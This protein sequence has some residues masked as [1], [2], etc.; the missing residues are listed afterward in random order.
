MATRYVRKYLNFDAKDVW[1]AACAAQRINNGSYI[2]LVGPDESGE[3]N[4]NIMNRMLADTTQITDA[5]RECGDTVR[6]YYNG[7][8][9]KVLKGIKLNEFNNTAM[10]IANRDT[11]T[12]MY[13]IAVIASLPSCWA[14]AIAYDNKNLRIDQAR[15]GFVGQ[16]GDKVD[17][18]L[19]ILKCVF[20]NNYGVFFATG[21]TEQDQVV[22][23]A[24]KQKLDLGAHVEITGTIKAHKDTSTQLTRVKFKG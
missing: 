23:F 13:D 21:I 11:I 1:A 10:V 7:L 12:D 2:K 4:R 17:V 5:D 8:T 9:F 22:F 24:H 6:K 20:S 16:V 18:T 14:R 3:T 15:G 19:E